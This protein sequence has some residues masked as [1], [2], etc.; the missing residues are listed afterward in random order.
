MD[1]Y[2]EVMIQWLQ[3]DRE[4]PRKQRH[5]SRRIW[6]RLRDEYGSTAAESTGRHYLARLRRD[7]FPTADRVFL[8]LAFDPAEAAQV[9]WGE[10]QMTLDGQLTTN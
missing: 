10:A 2:R 8:D 6:Q 3:D 1:P 7:L 4:V 9:D 5:T